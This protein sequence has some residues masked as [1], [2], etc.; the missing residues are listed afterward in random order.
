MC[1][2]SPVLAVI[3]LGLGRRVRSRWWIVQERSRNLEDGPFSTHCNQI[4]RGGFSIGRR[5]GGAGRVRHVR[6]RDGG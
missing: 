1:A 5:D 2:K 4:R 6:K 3:D